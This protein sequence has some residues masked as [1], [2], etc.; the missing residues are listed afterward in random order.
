MSLLYKLYNTQFILF[1]IKYRIF[2]NKLISG[3]AYNQRYVTPGLIEQLIALPCSCWDENERKI[4]S[5][6]EKSKLNI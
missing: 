3:R 5:I 1:Y 6:L 2:F 4:A